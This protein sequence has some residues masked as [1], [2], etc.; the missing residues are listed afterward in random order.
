MGSWSNRFTAL[1]DVIHVHE[2]YTS[3]SRRM[4]HRV[5]ATLRYRYDGKQYDCDRLALFRTASR[6]AG[7]LKAAHE[8]HQQVNLF[9][10]PATPS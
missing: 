3:T 6:L 1:A 7:M 5:H 4:R 8:R 2:Q 9:V 10:D